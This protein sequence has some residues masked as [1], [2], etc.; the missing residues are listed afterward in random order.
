MRTNMRLHAHA[1]A[2][3]CACLCVTRPHLDWCPDRHP[4][5]PVHACYSDARDAA[6]PLWEMDYQEQLLRKEREMR[7]VVLGICD[8]LRAREKAAV[9]GTRPTIDGPATAVSADTPEAEASRSEVVFARIAHPPLEVRSQARCALA[10][11]SG[12]IASVHSS[13][14]G[15]SA[16]CTSGSTRTGIRTYSMPYAHAGTPSFLPHTVLSSV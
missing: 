14:S 12:A 11:E 4:A 3:M 5:A 2:C 16:T 10:A 6:S 8:G 7:A 1:R 15:T 13:P 9:A